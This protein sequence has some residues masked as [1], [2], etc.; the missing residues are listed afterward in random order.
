MIILPIS[1][2]IA[3]TLSLDDKVL[4]KIIINKYN[5]HKK[6]YERDQHKIRSFDKLHRKSLTIITDKIEYEGL[7]NIFTK[8]VDETK[9]ESFL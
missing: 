8:Y 7:C 4:H 2:G 1:A 5:K 3:W 9:N 6:Q